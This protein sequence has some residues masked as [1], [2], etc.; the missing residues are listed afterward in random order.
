MSAS[1]SENLFWQ[2]S[3]SVYDQP[4]VAEACLALQARHELDVNLLLFCCWAGA[5][6]RRV[7]VAD[8]AS[9][10]AATADWQRRVVLP[11][12]GVR[13]WLKDQEAAPAEGAAVLRE[14]IKAREL[15]AEGLEQAI[16]AQ[17]LRIDPDAA[18]APG[19]AVASLNAYFTHLGREPGVADAADLAQILTAVFGD[20]LRP[21]NAVWDVQGLENA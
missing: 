4:G 10:E 2:F 6:G 5:H 16:L 17:T 15:E 21:L 9:L 11:L 7:S 3:L 20:R 1:G 18:G 13:D 8:A 12:R 14:G 19:D